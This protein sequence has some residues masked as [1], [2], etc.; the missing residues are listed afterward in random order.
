MSPVAADC[1]SP[2]R[3]PGAAALLPPPL[4]AVEVAPLEAG[5]AGVEAAPA[6][7]DEL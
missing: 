1:A 7:T 6:D 5:T 4:V 2:E 3:A